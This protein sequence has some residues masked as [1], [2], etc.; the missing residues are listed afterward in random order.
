MRNRRRS[1]GKLLA[2]LAVILVGIHAM[3]YMLVTRQSANAG[4]LAAWAEESEKVHQAAVDRVPTRARSGPPAEGHPALTGLHSVTLSDAVLATLRADVYPADALQPERPSNLF[5]SL[6][7]SGELPVA[8][9]FARRDE[10]LDDIRGVMVSFP[11]DKYVLLQGLDARRFGA[12]IVPGAVSSPPAEI[13]PLTYLDLA[14]RHF[15]EE[16]T[17]AASPSVCLPWLV[18][19]A[20]GEGDRARAEKLLLRWA[21]WKAAGQAGAPEWYRRW[22]GFNR[23]LTFLA[24]AHG[25]GLLRDEAL[26]AL[27]PP[28]AAT[29][30][31]PDE[32]EGLR[33]GEIILR[34]RECED[35]L[36]SSFTTALLRPARNRN[37]EA[38]AA[39][40]VEHSWEQDAAKRL[41][42]IERLRG[43]TRSIGMEAPETKYVT[44]PHPRV[45]EL[46]PTMAGFRE[47]T[48]I[49]AWEALF[50]IACLRFQLREGRWPASAA[51]IPPDLLPADFSVDT[52][53][54]WFVI[55]LK[56]FQFPV[57]VRPLDGPSRLSLDFERTERRHARS[58]EELAAWA[59]QQNRPA[60]P[61]PFRKVPTG[62]LFVSLGAA[63]RDFTRAD[64]TRINTFLPPSPEDEEVLRAAE[65]TPPELA[66]GNYFLRTDPTRWPRVMKALG[67]AAKEGS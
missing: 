3:L 20:Y 44:S 15:L 43:R 1:L 6:D 46:V 7:A 57:V 55:E 33:R 59:R 18:A 52:R 62:P 54:E 36:E 5:V 28:I 2:G 42:F 64:G 38:V 4:K 51:E 8:G 49:P 25:Q 11:D 19:R 58:P 61:P 48:N 45:L 63:P 9:R 30:L 60:T 34:A 13:R 39:A 67:L 66:I 12:E 23:L 65:A 14:E 24:D 29:V 56:N 32:A 31:T 27:V 53:R 40:L 35:S 22:T 50:E 47:E 16:E 41:D 37:I 10:V 26:A 17:S 21:E